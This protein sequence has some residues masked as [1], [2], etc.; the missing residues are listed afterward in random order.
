MVEIKWPS[1]QTQVFHDVPADKFY[2]IEEGN[3]DLQ[4]QHFSAPASH[5][6]K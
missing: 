2:L 4:Q 3:A 5:T 6:N 1:G